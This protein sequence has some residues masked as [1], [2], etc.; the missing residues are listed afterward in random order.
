MLLGLSWLLKRCV[1]ASG[2]FVSDDLPQNFEMGG[3]CGLPKI[4]PRINVN[5]LSLL[6]QIKYSTMEEKYP[7]GKMSIYFGS[8]TGTAMGFAKLLGACCT[9]KGFEVKVIDLG[10]F[11]PE[12]LVESRLALFLVATYGEGDPTDNALRFYEWLCNPNGTIPG[13]YL[14]SVSFAVF[15][16]GNSTYVNYNQMGKRCNEKLEQLGGQRIFPFAC[17]DDSC[18]L[19]EDFEAWKSNILEVLTKKYV[20]NE[21]EE[22]SVGMMC[23][24]PKAHL[25]F[26]TE[27]IAALSSKAVIPA[28]EINTAT[29]YFFTSSAIR[30]AAVRDLRSSADPGRTL[31]FEFDLTGS[32]IKY[33]PADNLAVI[34]E[35]SQAVVESF[36]STCG[37]YDLSQ[38]IRL[39]PLSDD[40]DVEESSITAFRHPFPNPCPVVT[41]FKHYLDISGIPRRSTL[42][43]FGPYVLDQQQRKWLGELTS[44]ENRAKYSKEIE[45]EGRTY[46]S[47]LAKELSSCVIPLDDLLHLIPYI[48]P[49]Y[50]TI[51]SSSSLSPDSLHL[52]GL[53]LHPLSLSLFKSSPPRPSQ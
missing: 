31:H 29:K 10:D 36:A 12:Q 15:G 8:Q 26:T 23:P 34:P 52:T 35:N 45:A 16:L 1:L 7:A 13:T 24:H 28:S 48:Q 19:E 42:E 27:P 25:T 47:L 49:R 22:M 38:C 46:A 37:G 33:H 39:L 9:R 44:K 43:R 2:S 4:G 21:V 6:S 50:Y 30:L 53:P 11:H 14:S 51:S 41:I 18:S 3:V 17:G 32:K 40:D 20:S 5:E